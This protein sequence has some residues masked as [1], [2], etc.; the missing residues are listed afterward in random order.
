MIN[1]QM[2]YLNEVR[3]LFNEINRVYV[4]FKDVD[5]TCNSRSDEIPSTPQPKPRLEII[6][7][8]ELDGAAVQVLR[9]EKNSGGEDATDSKS[10]NPGISSPVNHSTPQVT[11]ESAIRLKKYSLIF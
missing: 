4:C 2:E 8:L 5:M 11:S 7:P 9:S 3:V 1:L 10:D 6:H